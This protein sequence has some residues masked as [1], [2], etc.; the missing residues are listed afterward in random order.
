M[1]RSKLATLLLAAVF[2]ATS[3][4]STVSASEVNKSLAA[5][6][7]ATLSAIDAI[8]TPLSDQAASEIRGEALPA[9]VIAALPV[10]YYYAVTYGVP[11]ALNY[12]ASLT[13]GSWYVKD[14]V[15]QGIK[16]YFGW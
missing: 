3:F 4:V 5:N 16:Q 14:Y 11:F 10:I 15:M 8:G 7:T 1:I 6:P 9:I 2:A 12:G 13:N